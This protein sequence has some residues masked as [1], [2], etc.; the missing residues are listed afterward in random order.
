MIHGRVRGIAPA[1]GVP[2]QVGLEALREDG[3]VLACYGDMADTVFH[4]EVG[5][6][7]AIL[8]RGYTLDSLMLRYQG[9]DWRNRSNWDCN[10]GCVKQLIQR[11]HILRTRESGG[12]NLQRS[13]QTAPCRGSI[14]HHLPHRVLLPRTNV[15]SHHLN[16]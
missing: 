5:A 13:L 8:E 10:A 15:H 14:R 2:P 6:S 4:A 7:A 1:A 12:A 11:L 16:L 3:R 9:T